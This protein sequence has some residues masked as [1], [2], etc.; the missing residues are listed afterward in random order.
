VGRAALGV[1]TQFFLNMEIER[2]T[3]ATGETALIGFNRLWR[4]SGLVLVLM[5]GFANLWPGWAMS[6]AT[7]T[8]YVFGGDARLV[9]VVALMVIG[10]SLTLAPVV[11]VALERLIFVKV[12]AVFTLV[13][14]AA[15]MVID[16]ET[17][18][19]L[20]AGLAAG[21]VPGHLGFAM[22][23]GRGRLCRRGRWTELVSEQLDSRQRLRHGSVYVTPGEPSEGRRAGHALCLRIRLRAHRRQPR[24]LAPMVATGQRRAGAELRAGD[25]HD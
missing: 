6:A 22:L 17:W 13:A 12:A 3:L 2:Y 1:I 10:A 14:L 20:P 21:H 16:G 18:R 7:L 8:T 11:Y 25:D 4:H 9:A 23:S 24:A 5:V 19:A 15:A